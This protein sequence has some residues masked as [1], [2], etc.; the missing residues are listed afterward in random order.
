MAT[1]T[2]R[3][4]WRSTS[5][6]APTAEAVLPD[7]ARF[8]RI[9]HVELMRADR[10]GVQFCLAVFDLG[11]AEPARPAD[12]YEFATYLMSR[13]RATDH[14]GCMGDRKVGVVLW[15]TDYA[16]AEI[17]TNSVLAG[18]TLPRKPAAEIY[19]HPFKRRPRTDTP[20]EHSSRGGRPLDELLAE[21]LPTWKR[22]VDVIGATAGLIVLWPLLLATAAAVK[23]TSR[24][25][26]LFKQQRSGLGG[27]PFTI[28]KFR[29]MCVDAEAKKGDLRKFSEQDGPA[30]KMKHDPRIT[31]IGRY[32]RKACLDELPQL[33]N[34]LLGD[35]SLVGPRPLPC[36][37]A[38]GCLEWERRRLFV[39]PG[40]T[41]IW[42]IEGKS[43][44]PF[45]EWMRMDIRYMTAR[46]FWQDVRLL[47]RT[48]AAV[49][50]HRA[51][52]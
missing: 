24:G 20:V 12:E 43:R 21:P 27:R 28:Y 42:Q 5:P 46:S 51:S 32:L 30:F 4:W 25:P 39:T 41:C 6:A 50:M 8:D 14:A 16:G 31:P 3:G 37:E 52:H 40:L 19:V 44:V 47:F 18:C 26:V 45:K 22:V 49:V 23:L 15:D 10:T 13:L 34:V 29:T 36:D 2:R 9:I 35:M 33:W 38:D 17:F 48:A 11:P 7:T 1:A